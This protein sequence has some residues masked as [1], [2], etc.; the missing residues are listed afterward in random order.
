MFQNDMNL[1]LE[2]EAT[3]AAK[4]VCKEQTKNM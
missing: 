2:K 3:W 1:R 4:C